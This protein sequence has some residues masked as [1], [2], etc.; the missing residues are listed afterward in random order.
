MHANSHSGGSVQAPEPG[1]RSLSLRGSVHPFLLPDASGLA[2]PFAAPSFPRLLGS[3]FS[4][5]AKLNSA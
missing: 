4:K 1:L 2:C 5:G 3:M